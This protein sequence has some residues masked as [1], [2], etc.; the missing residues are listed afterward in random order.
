VAA[1]TGGLVELA[2]ERTITKDLDAKLSADY[3]GTIQEK[4]KNPATQKALLTLGEVLGDHVASELVSATAGAISGTT[5][6]LLQDP[7]SKELYKTDKV[8]FGKKVAIEGGQNLV[9][10]FVG[11]FGTAKVEDMMGLFSGWLQTK[12]QKK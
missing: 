11:A 3:A 5:V 10:G 7:T 9:A 6:K 12:F 2:V 1:V 4:V 8:A